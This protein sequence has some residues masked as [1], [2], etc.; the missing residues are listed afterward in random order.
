MWTLFFYPQINRMFWLWKISSIFIFYCE[1]GGGHALE[2]NGWLSARATSSHCGHERAVTLRWGGGGHVNQV[3]PRPER[4]SEPERGVH[5]RAGG[6][7]QAERHW[8]PNLHGSE[9]NFQFQRIM[10]FF[11]NLF[12]THYALL[13]KLFPK[14]SAHF[15]WQNRVMLR[16]KV[17]VLHQHLSKKGSLVS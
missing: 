4:G 13:L 14:I 11:Y 5:G 7:A 2:R 6:A 3:V 8:K 10:F 17:Q 16:H 12:F 1:R 15:S 9:P